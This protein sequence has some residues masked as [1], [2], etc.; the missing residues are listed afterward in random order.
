MIYSCLFI[1]FI[2]CKQAK[3]IWFNSESL[4]SLLSL[5]HE[6][7]LSFYQTIISYV[8]SMWWQILQSDCYWCFSKHNSFKLNHFCSEV[9]ILSSSNNF[10]NQSSADSSESTALVQMMLSS[11]VKSLSIAMIK[12]LHWT[13]AMTVYMLMS[14]VISS[15]YQVLNMLHVNKVLLSIICNIFKDLSYLSY[16]FS[17]CFILRS[18]LLIFFNNLFVWSLSHLN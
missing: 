2:L 9:L 15:Y 8:F 18:L 17:Y 10:Q 5:L 1:D 16:L 3:F 11:A 12:A 7:D 13:T 14:S 6:V 4:I